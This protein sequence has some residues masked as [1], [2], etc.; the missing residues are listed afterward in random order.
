MDPRH[1]TQQKFQPKI[2]IPLYSQSNYP[3]SS[4][5]SNKFNMNDSYNKPFI[6]STLSPHMRSPQHPNQQQIKYQLEANS[7]NSKMDQLRLDETSMH[8]NVMYDHNQMQLQSASTSSSSSNTM[9]SKFQPKLQYSP[10]NNNYQFSDLIA[11]STSNDIRMIQSLEMRR[12]EILRKLKQFRDNSFKHTTQQQSVNGNHASYHLSAT[13]NE[14]NKNNNSSNAINNNNNNNNA[15]VTST[16]ISQTVHGNH[17]VKSDLVNNYWNTAIPS[18]DYSYQKLQQPQTNNN[19]PQILCDNQCQNPN[20]ELNRDIFVRSD[21]ILTDDDYVPFEAPAQSKFGP[22]SRMSAKTSPFSNAKNDDVILNQT[23]FNDTASVNNL[24]I[25]TDNI[26]A[27]NITPTTTQTTNLND[28][29]SV[30]LNSLQKSPNPSNY[31]A[32]E[33]TPFKT[34]IYSHSPAMSPETML[35]DNIQRDGMCYKL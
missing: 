12:Q 16:D 2:L 29:T 17:S 23:Y 20:T 26:N 32:N 6:K 31:Q 34:S 18:N 1:F 19:T 25:S 15:T 33:L 14:P 27:T 13:T 11:T 5:A 8:P 3:P 4:H 22:I 24:G 10:S 30:W 28:Q 21:S 7:M 9:K 35:N